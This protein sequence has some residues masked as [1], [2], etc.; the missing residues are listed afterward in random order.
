MVAVPLVARGR[1]LG[2]I[3]LGIAV[4][5]RRYGAAEVALAQELARRAAIAVD[6]ARLYQAAQEAVRLRDE[7]LTV[8]SHEL[9]T[10]IATLRLSVEPLAPDVSLPGEA[11]PRMLAN[12]GRQTERLSKLVGQMLEVARIQAGDVHPQRETIDLGALIRD[13]TTRLADS[14]ARARCPLTLDLDAAVVGQWDRGAL[15]RVLESLLSN[16]S[17]FGSGK[18]IQVTLRSAPAS[19]RFT[20]RDEGI[21]IES[22]QLPRIFDRFARGVPATHYGGLGLG[23]Y[24]ARALVLSLSGTITVDSSPGQGASFS[25]TLP[26]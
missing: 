9:N 2:A 24:I 5:S 11:I 12:V 14:L 23:L 15:E 4:T 25:V 3:T 7:F 22:G 19:A 18:P 13:V 17:K 8:A 26:R 16:A 6:N 1:A 21:G 20:V 10:P